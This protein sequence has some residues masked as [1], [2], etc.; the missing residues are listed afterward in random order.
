[1]TSLH[2]KYRPN[3]FDEVVGQDAVVKALTDVIERKGTQAYLFCGPAG[4]GKT[5]LA[6]IVAQEYGCLDGAVTEIDAATFTGVDDMRKVQ[7]LL[8]YRAF[9]KSKYRAVILDE[10]HRLS[11]QAW[12]SLLKITEKPPRHAIW[13]LC[14]T[15]PSKL[16]NTIR[17]RF[18]TFTL[19]PVKDDQ[20]AKL[21]EWVC[22]EERIKLSDA[23]GDMIIKEANGSPRQMLV[24]LELCRSIT[25]RKE[26]AALLR[27]AIESDPTIELCRL[28]TGGGS[29][30]RAMALV[31]KLE[32][33]NPESVRI[34]VMNYIATMLK[35]AKTDEAACRLLQIMDAFAEPYIH[36][37]NTAPLLRSIGRALFTE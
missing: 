5:T 24:N 8:Q 26:A 3:S 10:A 13:L 20:L 33:T 4:I 25:D 16:P 6:R 12:D 11:S 7:T 23:I 21:Y 19:N 27:S 34:I 22:A 15:N 17:T 36:S 35:G 14:T 28:V 18:T 37:E 1:M 30:T 31:E 2:D 29:W 9:G 32:D